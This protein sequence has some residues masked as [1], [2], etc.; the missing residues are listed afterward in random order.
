[1]KAIVLVDTSVLLNVLRVPAK[2]GARSA[3]LAQLEVHILADDQLLLPMATVL[4]TGNHIGQ[5]KQS[6]AERRRCASALVELVHGAVTEHLPW[7]LV[8]LPDQDALLSWLDEF[9][10]WAVRGVGLG[11]VSIVDAWK[12]AC[13]Q[14]QGWRVTVWSLDTHLQGYDRSPLI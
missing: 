7:A 14:F 3:V 11:D 10:D 9:P 5:I 13:S 1:M 6:G 4:E 2:S 12:R 8:P